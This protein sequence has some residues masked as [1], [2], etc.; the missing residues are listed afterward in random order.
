[1]VLEI[2]I[3]VCLVYDSLWTYPVMSMVLPQIAQW[4]NETANPRMSCIYPRPGGC[5]R[6]LEAASCVYFAHSAFGHTEGMRDAFTDVHTPL[7][8][9]PPVH[10]DS[11]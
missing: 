7:S 9:A 6:P 2:A 1:M 11:L 5:M 8:S 10:P 3:G 4:K